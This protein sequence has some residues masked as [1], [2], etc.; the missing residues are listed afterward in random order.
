LPDDVVSATSARYLDAFQRI[1]GS[2]LALTD[3]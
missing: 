2:A 1:T 3:L